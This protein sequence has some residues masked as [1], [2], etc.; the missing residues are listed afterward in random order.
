MWAA[1]K[2]AFSVC[3]RVAAMVEKPLVGAFRGE[4]GGKVPWGESL[5]RPAGLVDDSPLPMRCK[6]LAN[7]V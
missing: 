4:S 1:L 3:P 2:V 5:G 7:S 6:L